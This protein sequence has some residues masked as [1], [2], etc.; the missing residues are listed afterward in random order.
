MAVNDWVIKD[1]SGV[2]KKV[3]VGGSVWK[4][5][6]L[7]QYHPNGDMTLYKSRLS[8]KN[9]TYLLEL[10]GN[11]DADAANFVG[12]IEFEEL[13]YAA[14]PS[15]LYQHSTFAHYLKGKLPGSNV[16][17]NFGGFNLIAYEI[18]MLDKEHKN[19][20]SVIEWEKASGSTDDGERVSTLWVWPPNSER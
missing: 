4:F 1:A 3:G 12:R 10:L 20:I 19:Y 6:G 8:H 16:N 9:G 13:E 14:D 2:V 5:G 15:D 7:E 17:N 11:W 18:H